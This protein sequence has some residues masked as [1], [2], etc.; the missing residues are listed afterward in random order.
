MTDK[1]FETQLPMDEK[2]RAWWKRITAFLIAGI[3]LAVGL[4]SVVGFL[5]W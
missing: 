3:V 4:I 1:H 2:T 5:G